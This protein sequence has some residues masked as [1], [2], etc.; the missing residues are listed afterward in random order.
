MQA[1]GTNL[2]IRG[3]MRRVTVGNLV[4]ARKRL[5]PIA[6]N[7][8]SGSKQ[9]RWI[10]P[11]AKVAAFRTAEMVSRWRSRQDRWAV[12]VDGGGCDERFKK[13][14]ANGTV[15]AGN[16]YDVIVVGAGIAGL[17]SAAY[18]AK[19]G[20]TTLLCEKAKR[21][22]AWW[23]FSRQGFTFDAGIRPFENSGIVSSDAS[24]SFRGLS[25]SLLIIRW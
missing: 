15:A 23:G 21:P 9:N 22:E 7:T 2:D 13:D 12:G 14:D 18:T 10:W 11:S 16:N 4:G 3:I 6:M 25:W 1:Q 24:A 20:F 5:K 8:R 17:T 19:A